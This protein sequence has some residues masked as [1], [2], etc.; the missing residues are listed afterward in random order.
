MRDVGPV[1]DESPI[2][3]RFAHIKIRSR[4]AE[5]LTSLP[6]MYSRTT[7]GGPVDPFI[8]VKFLNS[9]ISTGSDPVASLIIFE[10][11]DKDLVGVPDPKYPGIVSSR[12]CS[13]AGHCLTD[14]S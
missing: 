4:V 10:W 5:W 1:G 11:R 3:F 6:G 8:L 13:R 9:T 7:W 2:L 14:V 12:A